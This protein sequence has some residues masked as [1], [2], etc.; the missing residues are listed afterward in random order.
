MTPPAPRSTR[1]EVRNPLLALPAVAARRQLP[2]DAQAALS[3]LLRQLSDQA[4]IKAEHCWQTKKPPMAAYRKAVSVYAK[5]T[6][7][8]FPL[9]RPRP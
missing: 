7:R 2:P 5:H 6:A 3:L 1:A 9:R 4:A 8:V